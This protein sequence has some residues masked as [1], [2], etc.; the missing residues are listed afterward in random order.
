MD[1]EKEWAGIKTHE[2]NNAIIRH[3]YDS[4]EDPIS[5]SDGST[6][7]CLKK[8]WELTFRREKNELNRKLLTMTNC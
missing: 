4:L 7:D 5:D 8:P 3:N 6:K 2:E 1:Q